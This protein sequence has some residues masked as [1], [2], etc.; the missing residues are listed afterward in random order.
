[1]MDFQ[2][3]DRMNDTAPMDVARESAPQEQ[4]TGSEPTYNQEQTQQAYQPNRTP[5]QTPVRAEAGRP[6]VRPP[7]ETQQ[8]VNAP[9]PEGSHA[10][11]TYQEWE[12]QNSRRAKKP[13]KPHSR[14]PLIAVLAVILA[15]AVFAGGIGV[16]GLIT[17]ANQSPAAGAQTQQNSPETDENLPTLQVSATPSSNT[18]AQPGAVLNGEQV[19]EK[20]VP[21]MV[22]V[23]SSWISQN[24]SGSG[25]GVVMTGDGYIITNAHVVLSEDTSAQA[26]KVSVVL[27]DGTTLPAQVI[28][29][30]ESTDLAVLKVNATDAL[31][32]AEFGDSDAL[33]PGQTCYA[34]GSP[35]GLQL[36]NTITTGSISAISR[37][38]TIND[39]V[40]S[41]IQ[42]DAAINPGNS[43]GAL[44]NQYGQI[45]GITSAKLGISYYEG[46][47]FAIPINSAKEI[48][49]QLIQYG[50]IAGRPQIGISGYNIDEAAAKYYNVPQGV[51]IDSIDSR[52][53]AAAAGMKRNDIIIGVN[54][55]TITTMDEINEVKNE[56][57]AGDSIT[58]RVHRI[59]TGEELD[60]T[61]ALNDEHDF[62]GDDPALTQSNDTTSN[63]TEG[64][65]GYPGG[66]YYYNPFYNFFGR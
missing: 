14:K 57:S 10:Y 9:F 52:S 39:N 23:Q 48:I 55:D 3:R 1:M 37:D 16:G 51:M 59:S 21:S 17:A 45:V 11:S 4:S 56:L 35:G 27:Y 61:F 20:C 38:I 6:Q 53:N 42:I 46:L 47:G 18:T 32:A 8:P 29:A 25:S 64:S 66:S 24:A 54:G 34:I 40:M 36:A 19:Y 13:R 44:I 15:F 5:Y 62:S 22:T 26:D 28:G 30:D 50:Y 7:E 12:A 65:G 63:N 41:L 49:D 31:V 60:F 43:G 2:D 33:K 58:L